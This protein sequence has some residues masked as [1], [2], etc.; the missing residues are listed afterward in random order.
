M[1]HVAPSPSLLLLPAPASWK[2]SSLR[3]ACGPTLSN[4]LPFVAKS[5]QGTNHV[6]RLDLAVVLPESIDIGNAPRATLFAPIQTLLKELYTLLCIIALETKV[7]LDFPGGVDARIFMLE[8]VRGDTSVTDAYSGPLLNIRT[9]VSARRPYD[10]VFS[11]ESE[12]GEHVLQAFLKAHSVLPNPSPPNVRRI[13]GGTS[14]ITPSSQPSTHSFA[15]DPSNSPR[16]HY[17]VAVGGTFDHLHIGHK[18]LLA[19]TALALS[20]SPPQSVRDRLITIGITGDELLV[21]KKAAAEVESWDLRQSKTADFFESIL[22]VSLT[23]DP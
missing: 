16:E 2:R 23:P 13:I 11:V 22:A 20:P 14:M 15:T 10:P 5:V 17:S 8:A 21:N 12:Q 19:G 3:T 6:A 4:V 7:E 9:L 18:L 1:A